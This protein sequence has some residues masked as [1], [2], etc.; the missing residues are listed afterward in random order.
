MLPYIFVSFYLD[1]MHSFIKP[2]EV[3]EYE[4]F[5]VVSY[6]YPWYMEHTYVVAFT[7]SLM[8]ILLAIHGR[9]KNNMK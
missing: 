3:V 5:E 8:L 4:P 2:T 6:V 9:G 1:I 7:Y